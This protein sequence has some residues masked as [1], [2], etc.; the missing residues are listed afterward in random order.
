MI[1]DSKPNAGHRALVELEKYLDVTIV[2]QN[3]DNFLSEGRKFESLSELHAEIFETKNKNAPP[4]VN[5]M[6]V[7][8]NL[9]DI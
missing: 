6:T 5:G 1:N 2:T 7:N 9:L 4:A 8:L 3:V